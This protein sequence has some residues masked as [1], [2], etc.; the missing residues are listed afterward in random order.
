MTHILTSERVSQGYMLS[1]WPAGILT[2]CTSYKATRHA[3]NKGTS[4]DNS[5]CFRKTS[6]SKEIV[7]VPAVWASARVNAFYFNVLQLTP[8]L[9]CPHWMNVLKM[10]TFGSTEHVSYLTH[11][12]TSE[13]HR[14]S[15]PTG[16]DLRQLSDKTL[17][18]CAS[19][20]RGFTRAWIHRNNE[21]R[22]KK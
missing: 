11:Y 2:T 4:Y 17:K 5:E 8:G 6:G 15:V 18:I 1:I 14:W 19:Q 10:L 9:Y 21:P 3:Q 12:C 20:K 16:S 7:T 13:F 22:R